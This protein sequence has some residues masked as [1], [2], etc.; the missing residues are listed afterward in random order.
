[1][2]PDKPLL[3]IELRYY[4]SVFKL[5][6]AV[7]TDNDE[8]PGMVASGSVKMMNLKV[9]LVVSLEEA[10]VTYLAMPLI[11]LLKQSPQVGWRTLSGSAGPSS[12]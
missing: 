10:K 11:E 3:V 8:V 7:S 5:I 1:M 6:V 9:W 2:H 4:F 12:G